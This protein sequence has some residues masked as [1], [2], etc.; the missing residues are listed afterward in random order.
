MQAVQ[1]REMQSARQDETFTIGQVAQLTKVNAKNIRYYEGIGLLPIPPRS[2]NKYRRY[3]M[4]D[5]NRLILLRRI[6]FLGVPLSEARSLLIGASDAQCADVQ[7]ELLGLV[8]A[9]LVAIDQEI[10]ELHQLREEMERYQRKLEGCHP[11]E[12]E[13]FRT[14]RD[15]SCIAI[16]EETIRKE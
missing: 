1:I 3:S 13:P 15:M 9:R 10:A 14:C 5:V 6:R 12:S 7:Q 2:A 16:S 4:A 11:D 8:N